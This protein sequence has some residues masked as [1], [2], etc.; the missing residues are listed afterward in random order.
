MDNNGMPLAHLKRGKTGRIIQIHRGGHGGHHG[1]YH[2]QHG[3]H[4]RLNV[5]GIREGQI[6]RVISK[7]PLMGP[8]TISVGNCQMTLGRGMAHKIIVEEL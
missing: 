3:F 4:K 6:V 2:G 7:Q 5:L 1:G 8:L